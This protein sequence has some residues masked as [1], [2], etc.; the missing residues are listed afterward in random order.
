MHYIFTIKFIG[1]RF[2]FQYGTNLMMTSGLHKIEILLFTFQYG[3]N[4]IIDVATRKP[5]FE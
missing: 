1:V 5:I 4:L 3:T 2:T